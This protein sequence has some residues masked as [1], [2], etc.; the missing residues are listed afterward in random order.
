M[1]WKA[2]DVSPVKKES[3]FPIGNNDCGSQ[4]KSGNVES[5][6]LA[7]T[8]QTAE[9]RVNASSRRLGDEALSSEQDDLD[10]L[11]ALL[12]TVGEAVHL[13]SSP[14]IGDSERSDADSRTGFAGDSRFLLWRRWPGVELL[15][16]HWA[17]IRKHRRQPS[18]SPLHFSYEKIR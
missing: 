15:Y 9:L 7:R 18:F 17:F 2:F 8:P 4:R 1:A 10:Q 11:Y 16:W 5:Q 3:L 12:K 13:G 6:S 14:F